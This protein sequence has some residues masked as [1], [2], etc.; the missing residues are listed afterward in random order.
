MIFN[1]F[2]HE[3]KLKNKATSNIKIQQVLSSLFLNDVGI[4]LRD[5]PFSNNIGFV[6]FYPSKGIHWVCYKNENYFDSYGCV[7]PKNLPE[8]II[9][10]NRHCFYSDYQI[11]K[12]IVFVQFNI[13]IFFI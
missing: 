4:Y 10:R 3:H 9:N 8:V 6:S 11:Q 13:Y 12:R 1:D 5:G 7:C 2:I